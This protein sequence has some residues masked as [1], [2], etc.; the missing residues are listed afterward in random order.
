MGEE[1]AIGENTEVHD[2]QTK[3]LICRRNIV[4]FRLGFP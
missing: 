3:G 4:I 1:M 2:K